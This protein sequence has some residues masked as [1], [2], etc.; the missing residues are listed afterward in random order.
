MPRESFGPQ[1]IQAENLE[2]HENQLR[3][4]LLTVQLEL[5][6]MVRNKKFPI[7]EKIGIDAEN[8]EQC[9]AFSGILGHAGHVYD[10]MF[11]DASHDDPLFVSFMDNVRRE[12]A[13]LFN[14]NMTP[15]P[16][17]I[18]EV[19]NAQKALLQ[20]A[21]K[22]LVIPKD[23]PASE[24]Y[25]HK[26]H[27]V[28][29]IRYRHT[30]LAWSKFKIPEGEL[31]ALGETGE[32][33]CAS[34]H[35]NPVFQQKYDKDGDSKNIFSSKSLEMF[36][37]R[38]ATEDNKIRFI[39]GRSWL[40]DTPIAQKV[41]FHPLKENRKAFD[42]GFWNQFITQEGQ[43]DKNRVEYLRTYGVPPYVVSDGYIHVEEFL[44]KHLPENMKENVVLK[45][46][47]SAFENI[48]KESQ[49]VYA[50][51]FS[52]WNDLSPEKIVELASTSKIYHDFSKT[53]YGAK[54]VQTIFDVKNTGGSA[55]DFQKKME[56]DQE[57]TRA[58]EEFNENLPFVEY[59][60]NLA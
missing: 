42:R 27:T 5:F 40:I 36:A 37:Q 22:V 32:S 52:K 26:E 18:I 47:N 20:E 34:I 11:P 23:I 49:R 33:E 43:L 46:E 7:Y 17:Q 3:E 45:K 41:G 1:K 8:I 16:K 54:L 55:E 9:I 2:S 4:Q 21:Q 58:F 15:T 60:P 53:E 39:L 25:Y 12:T 14:G 57:I 51:I 44:K 56:E 38:I 6:N 35:F 31:Y 28:G 10:A 30:K 48:T 24:A 59:H 19:L 29:L 13:A 50:E